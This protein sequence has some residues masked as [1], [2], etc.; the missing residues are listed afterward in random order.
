ML[1]ASRIQG[2]PNQDVHKLREDTSVVGVAFLFPRLRLPL[3][4]QVMSDC[5]AG[6]HV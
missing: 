1:T 4:I 2:K 3:T 5:S 6:L